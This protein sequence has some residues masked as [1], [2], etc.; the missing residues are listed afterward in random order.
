MRPWVAA[1]VRV[2][3]EY[4]PTETVVGSCVY[5]LQ[6]GEQERSGVPIGRP[7]DNTQM[8]V[9]DQ[10][11]QPVA[12]GVRGEIYIGGAGVARGYSR[13]AEL[14][15]ERFVPHPYSKCPVSVYTGPE[16]KG[17]IWQMGESSIWAGATSR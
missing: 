3:N 2:Y 16:M 9:L 7:I 14:T 8:Y 17:A 4:G 11:Q 10:W 1:G 12:V 15:A 13:R 5:E 6:A